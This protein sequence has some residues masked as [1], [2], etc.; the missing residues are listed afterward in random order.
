I[1]RTLGA[2]DDAKSPRAPG[3]LDRVAGS[4]G[5]SA[6]ELA[7]TGWISPF[8]ANRSGWLNLALSRGRAEHDDAALAFAQRRLVAAHLSSRYVDWATSQLREE[9]IAKAVDPEALLIKA[10]AKKQLGSS[11]LGRAALDDLLDIDAAQ[12]DRTP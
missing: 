1:V 8:G 2:G 12:K 9:P 7:M 11:G 10:L 6:D 5:L 3:L 4:P